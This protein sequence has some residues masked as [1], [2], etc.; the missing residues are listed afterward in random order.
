MQI[1]TLANVSPNR[2]SSSHSPID[3]RGPWGHGMSRFMTSRYFSTPSSPDQSKSMTLIS[4]PSASP[5]C[6]T[7]HIILFGRKSPMH[8]L[9]LLLLLEQLGEFRVRRVHLN[10]WMLLAVVAQGCL[11]RRRIEILHDNSGRCTCHTSSA[12]QPRCKAFFSKNTVD[13][14]VAARR[15]NKLDK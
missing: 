2:V 3:S 4:S 8:H 13:V 10:F 15:I 7:R 5:S 12:E 9:L 6:R 1:Y 14:R 11:P